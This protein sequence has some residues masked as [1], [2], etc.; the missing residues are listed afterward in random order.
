MDLNLFSLHK[1]INFYMCEANVVW[2]DVQC[3][4]QVQKYTLYMKRNEYIYI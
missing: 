3:K 1:Q 2:L 4:A